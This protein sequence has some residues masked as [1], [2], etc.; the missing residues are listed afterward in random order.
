MFFF[1]QVSFNFSFEHELHL[2]SRVSR[3]REF[4]TH[5]EE[6]G[7]ILVVKMSF[8]KTKRMKFK[9]IYFFDVYIKII[10]LLP[11]KRLKTKLLSLGPHMDKNNS[12]G[13]KN[14]VFTDGNKCWS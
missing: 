3:N 14:N 10:L 8:T 1:F 5:L 2:C 11:K 7:W 12:P 4:K 13:E 6:C 9:N